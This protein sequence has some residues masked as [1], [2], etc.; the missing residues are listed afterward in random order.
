MTSRTVSP[1]D[2]NDF[3]ASVHVYEPHRAGLPPLVP[4]A[5][6]LVRRHEFASELSKATLRA[7]NSLTLFGQVWLI[8]NP[9]LLA[10]VYFFLVQVLS[11]ANRDM[12]F[13]SHLTAGLFTFYFVSGSIS[14]GA[15]AI[16]SGGRLLLNTSFPRLLMPFGAVRTAFFRFLPTVP[17][18]FVF[19]LWAGNPIRMQTLCALP[20]LAMIVAFSAGMAALVSALAV[21]FRDISSFLPYVL[22]IWLYVSPVIWLV[23]QVPKRLL[24]LA[25]WN[26]LFPMIG[27]FTES[28][29]EGKVPALSMWLSGIAWSIGAFVVG[30]LFFISREREFAVRI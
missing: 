5:R 21:Y 27:G 23:D 26:P 4:Y 15:A 14:S 29:T 2:E 22:R 25:V 19:H 9:L 6:E 8:L 11:G 12:F 18:F 10:A 20:F 1:L 30:S 13:F 17:V 24:A 28:L 16:V 7:A 3:T